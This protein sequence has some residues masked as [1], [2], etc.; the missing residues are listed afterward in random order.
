[1]ANR[2]RKQRT[3]AQKWTRRGFIGVGG[4]AG[5]GLVAAGGFYV[6]A[7]KAIK[8]YSGDGL[9]EGSSVNAWIRIAPDN[10]ISLAFARAEMGQGVNTAL[11]QLVAEELNVSMESINVVQPQPESPYANTYLVTQSAPNLFKSYSIG[12]TLYSFIPIIGTG[13]STSI[14]DG[15]NNM[16]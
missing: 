4:L 13:G 15:W 9:G 10:S 8:G 14:S 3:T 2:N 1:M 12:E 6:H 16:R 11:S 5:V 7:K